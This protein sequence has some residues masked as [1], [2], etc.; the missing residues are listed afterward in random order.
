MG[1]RKE[2]TEWIK[3]GL[4]AVGTAITQAVLIAAVRD[5][6]PVRRLLLSGVQGLCALGLVDLA[7]AFTAV[8]LGLSWFT[9]AVCGVLGLPGVIG[10]LLLKLIF[11][12]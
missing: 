10:L 4:I 2:M 1:V 12:A 6:K 11:P 7:G 9:V 5:G 3:W 8:S